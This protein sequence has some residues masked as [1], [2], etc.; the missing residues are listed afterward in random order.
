[1]SLSLRRQQNQKI[2]AAIYNIQK[3]N[4]ENALEY[5]IDKGCRKFTI[6]TTEFD[7]ILLQFM[8]QLSKNYSIQFSQKYIDYDSCAITNYNQNLDLNPL[9]KYVL[10]KKAKTS[11]TDNKSEIIVAGNY[12]FKENSASLKKIDANADKLQ[13]YFGSISGRG[14]ILTESAL[15]LSTQHDEMWNLIYPLI[16][17]SNQPLIIGDICACVGVDTLHF[18]SKA[19]NI[20]QSVISVECDPINFNALKQNVEIAGLHYKIILAYG[21]FAE[22]WI[23]NLLQANMPNL[24]YFAPPNVNN[25]REW[26][27]IFKNWFKDS[28]QYIVVKTPL[29]YSLSI[30]EVQIFETKKNA[31]YFMKII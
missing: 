29:D 8:Y 3:T 9:H 5:V 14:I 10:S 1:M 2:P 30:P 6:Y 7:I 16:E 23:V 22:K 27:D 12:I 4:F 28:L 24:I 18:A 13:E 31:I 21:S 25:I 19:N 15:T 26:I 20:V 11:D 17:D